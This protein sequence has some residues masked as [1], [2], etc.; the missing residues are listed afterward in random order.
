MEAPD[1]TSADYWEGEANDVRLNPAA[2]HDVRGLESALEARE[3]KASIILATSGTSGAAKLVVLPKVA[4]LHSARAVIDWCA[5]SGNDRWL[6][7]LSTF[8]VGG[9]GVYS[10]AFLTKSRVNPMAWHEWTRDGKAFLTSIKDSTVTSLTPIH[11]HDL[12]AAR[13]SSPANLRGVFIG[14]GSLSVELARGAQDLGWHL[15]PTYG[16]TEACS[17][18]AT[19]LSGNPEWLPI[20][21]HWETRLS[22]S[23]CLQIK[24]QA[25]MAGY[26]SRAPNGKWQW[27]PASD[28]SGF[29]TTEDQVEIANGKLKVIGRADHQVKIL[30]ELVCVDKIETSLAQYLGVNAVVS[31]SANQRRGCDLIAIIESEIDLSAA[32]AAWNQGQPP[33]QQIAQV[34]FVGHFPRTE[35]GK[36]DRNGVKSLQKHS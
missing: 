35:V 34:H 19:S 16:M 22:P 20:L 3:I 1:L 30:G 14:G 33:Y 6:G 21:A 11:L 2:N 13:V 7:G 12:V 10:R 27:Y 5:L 25:L 23:G 9:L 36:I 31:T 29:F 28:E 4:M 24:G 32:F 18:I 15:W 26:F 17:Q 8:H